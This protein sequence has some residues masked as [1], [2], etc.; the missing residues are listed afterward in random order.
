MIIYI[1]DIFMYSK[2]MEEHVDHLEY[3]L[4]KLHENKKIQQ[5]E[6]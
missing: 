6:K 5:G 1:D 3:V 2:T 4:N